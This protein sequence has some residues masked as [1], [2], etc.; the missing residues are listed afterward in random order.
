MNYRMVFNTIGKVLRI[1][2]ILLL[3]PTV[4]AM[5]YTEWWQAFALFITACIA[6]VLGMGMV[7]LCKPKNRFVYAKEGL[8]T[9]ALA[10]LAVSLVGA[11]PFVISGEIPNYIDALFETVSGFT[12]TGASILTDV[13]SMS[14]GM[15]FWRSF[16]HWIGGMGVLV[17]FLAFSGKSDDRSI[18]ILRAEMPGPIVDKVTPKAR[19]TAIIL[20]VIYMALTLVLL[21]MLLFG[22]MDLFESAIHAFGT[23]GTGGFGVKADGIASYSPYI[24]WVIAVFMML[25]G[26]NFN[27]YYLLILGKIGSFFKSRELWVYLGIIFT[28]TVAIGFNVFALYGNIADTVRISFFQVS[29]LMTS[30]GF[31]T[32]DFAQWSAMAR[33]VLL[34]LMFVGACAGS[35]GG[36]FKVSRLMILIKK[37]VNDLKKVLHPR[38]STVVKMEGK[39]LDEETLNGASSYLTVYV[40]IFLVVFLLLSL[41]TGVASDLAVETNLSATLA[42]LNN[43]G[44]GLGAI[45][46]MSSYAA[47]SP[48]SKILLSITM[49]LGRLEIY[50]LLLTLTPMT[51][52]KK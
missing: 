42:C 36:G 8:V 18:H 5:I 41:D 2:S 13:E 49:L 44:P 10:W 23:A 6:F 29:S 31:A 37:T 19:D 43:I 20:Y 17:F 52:L 35:T 32:A 21:I 38:T 9:V 47:Y 12:T 46:P 22:G 26:V 14:K 1:E 33:T 3:L 34:M 7:F 45:G 15:L 27:L 25:F 51:W 11:L 16:T 39:R 28:A 4:V 50:P 48:L 30:T 40:I 24:Q